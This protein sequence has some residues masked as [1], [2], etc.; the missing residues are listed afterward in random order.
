MNAAGDD[1]TDRWDGD[2]ETLAGEYAL[3]IQD[4]ALRKE[5]EARIARDPEFAERVARWQADFSAIDDALPASAPPRELFARI[6]GR[7]FG[8]PTARPGRFAS[9]W[10][11]VGLWQGL[12]AASLVAVLALGALLWQ[13][14]WSAQ[15]PNALIAELSAVG[16]APVDLVAHYDGGSGRMQLMAASLSADDARVMELWLIE[17]ADAA[18]VSLGVVG[19]DGEGVMVIEAPMRARLSEGAV[20]AVSLE[21]QGGSPTGQPT[22]PVIASG[23]VRRP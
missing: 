17:T 8:V 6:E 9:L 5:L 3:G 19:R 20:L 11:S 2:D 7:I 18:P 22:G 21:P 16:D 13:G 12:A 23:E 10:Q 15:A 1:D 4:L 14:S